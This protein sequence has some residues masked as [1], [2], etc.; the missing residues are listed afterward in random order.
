MSG[1][2][3]VSGIKIWVYMTPKLALE[4]QENVN[5]MVHTSATYAPPFYTISMSS[6]GTIIRRVWILTRSPGSAG[7]H[8]DTKGSQKP[9]ATRSCNETPAQQRD[10]PRKVCATKPLALARNQRLRRLPAQH[11]V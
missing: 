8:W 10:V 1:I 11:F 9:S 5:A 7:W 4:E 6:D 2:E 3:G